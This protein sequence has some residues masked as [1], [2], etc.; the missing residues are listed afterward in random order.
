MK[1]AID[2][3]CNALHNPTQIWLV[4]CKN[5]ETNEYFKFRN[6]TSDVS[7]KDKFLAFAGSVTLWVGHH[8][9][10]FD[11]PVL[12]SLVG[13]EV[14][15]VANRCVDTLVVSKLV[16]YSRKAHS[17]QEYGLEFGF[18][19]GKSHYVD[20]FK[21][22]SQELEDYCVRDVDICHRIYNKYLYVITNASWSPSIKLEQ[23]F[24][25]VVNDLNVNGFSFNV[26][27]AG[28]ILDRVSSE[29]SVLD[30]EILDAFPPTLSEIREVHP[31]LTGHGTLN[32]SD[33]RFVKSGD[34]SEYNGGPFSRC[35]WKRFNPS[36]HSQ[37]IKVLSGAG[38]RP[39]DKTTTHIETEREISRL[40]YQKR[41]TE[42]DLVLKDLYTKINNLRV[43]GWKINENNL[44]TLPDTAP[45]PARTLA[46]RILLESRRRTLTEWLGLVRPDNRI[47][48]EFFGIGAW[49]HRMAHQKPNTANIPTD[50]K[51]YGSEMRSLWQ[52]PP[53]RLL[54]G[55]DAEGIQ[56][57]IFAHY[58]DDKEFTEAL[59]RG[60]K[61]D[62][63][64]PHSLNQRILGSVCKSRQDAKRFIYA[65]LLGAGNSKL[66]QV[67]GCDISQAEE[68]LNRLLDRYAGLS[69]L[70]TTTIPQ[71]AKRGWF[72]GLDGR[73]A[74]IPGDTQG[75]RKHLVMSGYLQNGEAIIVKRTVLRT[76]R[77]L[78]QL[79]RG[80]DVKLVNVVHDEVI[81]EV[82]ND[83]V[84]AQEVNKI[85]CSS[86]VEVGEELGLRC[87]LA[88]DGH[89]GRDWSQI[90]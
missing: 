77:K 60:S 21:S 4:V 2:T 29:L 68:G 84:L 14:P 9:L 15:D 18:E 56:L 70:K 20:F 43:T 31:R 63:T 65:Y 72:T 71:D 69:L 89:I 54:V 16:D 66:A 26:V 46:K 3:E 64:D 83:Q 47:H 51:L 23:E 5:I 36:S 59:V 30:K 37:I 6:I 85:F 74:A 8:F 38:W 82:P 35:E 42:L 33:F 40:K 57:R 28:K 24:Q 25:L 13:L 12:N 86:I 45:S 61:D 88:G 75:S 1:I 48:G 39:T 10:G 34:L 53:R 52:A 80:A 55:A 87:P 67:L 90:H 62:K 22:W 11:Y 81:F 19:K 79:Y 32:K 7:E 17:I 76:C 44:S 58:I 73:R 50:A 49:T 27:K 41:D 78:K